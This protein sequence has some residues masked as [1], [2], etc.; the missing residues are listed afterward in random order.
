MLSRASI[1]RREALSISAAMA[2]PGEVAILF[3]SVAVSGFVIDGPLFFI[4]LAYAFLSALMIPA[5][6]FL[7][8]NHPTS[9]MKQPR[10]PIYQ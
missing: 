2:F 8:S 7:A 3:L 4:V 10:E 6:L 9:A 5:L 1:E